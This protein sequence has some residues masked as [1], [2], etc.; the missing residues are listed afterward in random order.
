MDVK[1]PDGTMTTSQEI[2][3]AARAKEQREAA[4][5]QRQES[6]ERMK[7][8]LQQ[9]D[10]SATPASLYVMGMLSDIQELLAGHPAQGQMVAVPFNSL[11]LVNDILNNAKHIISERLAKK[12]EH[13][14]HM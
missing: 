11:E 6:L 4:V 12:D 5:K 1:L 9:A 14:R 3:Y 13:G 8:A 7:V 2:C 10:A